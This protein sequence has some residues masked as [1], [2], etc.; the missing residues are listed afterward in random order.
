MCFSLYGT[1][2]ENDRQ[3]LPLQTGANK[4]AGHPVTEIQYHHLPGDTDENHEK[5]QDSRHRSPDSNW[6][7][8]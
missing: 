6:E 4:L 2:S 7:P 8:L 1:V 5:P 3:R